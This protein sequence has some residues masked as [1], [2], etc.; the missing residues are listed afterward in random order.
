[1]TGLLFGLAPALQAAR[2][3]VNEAVKEGARG[4]APA[5]T[6][7]LSNAFVVAQIALSLGLL[8]GAALLLQS[9]KNLLAVDPGFR[10]ANVLTARLALPANRYPEDAKSWICYTQ[11]PHRAE[12][13]PLG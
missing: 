4:S 5:S 2:V 10:P 8:I 13:T 12:Q 6:R 9:F 3:N 11:P 1:F 7:Q